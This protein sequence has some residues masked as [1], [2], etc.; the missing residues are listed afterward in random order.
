MRDRKR[1]TVGIGRKESGVEG[2]RIFGKAVYVTLVHS[3]FR[4]SRWPANQISESG[5][6]LFG[7]IVAPHAPLLFFFQWNWP[8]LSHVISPRRSWNDPAV[9]TIL[10]I[11]S[12]FFNWIWSTAIPLSHPSDRKPTICTDL[13]RLPSPPPP[14]IYWLHLWKILKRVSRKRIDPVSLGCLSLGLMFLRY[15]RFNVIWFFLVIRFKVFIYLYFFFFL[16]RFQSEDRNHS[17]RLTN[18]FSLGKKFLISRF[19][20]YTIKFY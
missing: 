18:F 7:S 1:D 15:I 14:F 13:C 20:P 8:N 2:S 6:K 3:H 4:V 9:S 19:T 17:S 10:L 16:R 12:G 5:N 11:T